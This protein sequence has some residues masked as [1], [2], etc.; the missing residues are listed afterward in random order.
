[1]PTALIWNVRLGRCGLSG[2]LRWGLRRLGML[3]ST[4]ARSH[5]AAAEESKVRAAEHL[6]LEHLQ[7]IAVPLDRAGAPGESDTGFDRGVVLREPGG[8][9]A[10]GLHRTGGRALEPGIEALDR[11][12]TRLNSSHSSI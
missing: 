9:A 6:T 1:M 11:K 10:Y 4:A 5:K 2:E 7:T 3:L 12:S 8:E